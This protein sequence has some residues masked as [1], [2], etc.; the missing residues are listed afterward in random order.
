MR[1]QSTIKANKQMKKKASNHKAN[2]QK[3]KETIMNNKN[4]IRNIDDIIMA[5]FASLNK[6]ERDRYS[7]GMKRM[8]DGEKCGYVDRAGNVVI[9]AQFDGAGN[10]FEGLA[11]VKVGDEWGYIDQTGKMII[12]PQWEWVQ[13]FREGLAGFVDKKTGN[14]GF[15][16]KTG[17]VVIKPHWTWVDGFDEGLAPFWS[18]KTEKYGFIDKTGKVVIKPHWTWVESF[19]HGLA[20]VHNGNK[21]GYIDKRGSVII[22]FQFDRV[23]N[24]NNNHQDGRPLAVV[25][26]RTDK[27]LKEYVID[28]DGDMVLDY[29]VRIWE[30]NING[31]AGVFDLITN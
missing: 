22:D 3:T 31:N 10:F 16:D 18:K 11:P 15:I 7:E 20:S 17:K 24:F 8:I 28:R 12:N 2:N 1:K 14:F 25:A 19:S 6:Y 9:D 5:N 13:V 30:D 27:R 4:V 29:P 26:V 23:M 21:W